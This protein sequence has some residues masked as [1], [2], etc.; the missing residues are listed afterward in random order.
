MSKLTHDQVEEALES[1]GPLVAHSNG[2]PA[3][4]EQLR[5]MELN[6][7]ID[8]V[9][10]NGVP[11][12]ILVQENGPWRVS[13]SNGRVS[14]ISDDFTHDVALSLSGDFGSREMKIAYAEQV[15][16]ALSAFRFSGAT[17]RET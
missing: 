2:S 10:I 9:L 17:E 15:A 8:Q 11:A 13:E 3:E 4:L 6:G 12:P 14:I 7:Q 1:V 16:K 5:Q